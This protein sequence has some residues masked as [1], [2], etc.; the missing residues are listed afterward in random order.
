VSSFDELRP[1]AAVVLSPQPGSAPIWNL[2]GPMRKCPHRAAVLHDFRRVIG[3]Q[4]DPQI[5]E[6]SRLL[7]RMKSKSP[8]SVKFFFAP[9]ST[10]AQRHEGQA[11]GVQEIEDLLG[12]L[13]RSAVIG[14]RMRIVY[15]VRRS[16]GA[17]DP[18]TAR[19][20]HRCLWNVE[21]L[22]KGVARL[23][24]GA[25][26]VLANPGELPFVAQYALFRAAD[27]LLGVHGSAF[28]WGLF[29]TPSQ[30]VIEM[31]L[32]GSPGLNDWLFATM[33]ARTACMQAC[34]PR[35]TS[36]GRGCSSEGGDVDVPLLLRSLPS[37]LHEV[38][39][40]KLVVWHQLGWKPNSEYTGWRGHGGH[41]KG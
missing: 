25:L 33:G 6:L 36:Y 31:P 32:P 13:Q 2:P 30:A 23:L 35:S 5:P 29:L 24:A 41:G 12:T 14:G 22:S 9:S 8:T 34:L 15:V 27:V 1:I 11:G 39:S 16:A 10:G 20:C 4:L 40:T 7:A 26:V 19:N 3:A 18:G 38:N 21:E 37:L 17:V 28:A